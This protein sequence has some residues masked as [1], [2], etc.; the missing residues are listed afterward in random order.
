MFSMSDD[1]WLHLDPP[2]VPVA[3]PS[4]DPAHRRAISHTPVIIQPTNQQQAPIACPAPLFPQTILE[5]PSFQIFKEAD[6]NNN[7]T[8]VSHLAG[9][10]CGQLYYN[11]PGLINRLYLYSGQ[12]KPIGWLQLLL[13][14]LDSF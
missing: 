5:N 11:S 12:E 6:L 14:Y 10:W 2:M 9:S 8:L 3:P 13:S 7:K 1:Q 4:I